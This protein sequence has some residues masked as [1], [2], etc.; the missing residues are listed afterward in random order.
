[1]SEIIY[2]PETGLF[3]KNGKPFGT[4]HKSGYIHFWFEGKIKLAH[5][6]AWKMY[7]GDWPNGQ[8]DHIN[9][10]KKDNRISN[11][12]LATPSQNRMN[13]KG[14][15]EGK[16]KGV[17]KHRSKFRSFVVVDGVRV[18]SKSFDTELEAAN[19]YQEQASLHYKEFARFEQ[20]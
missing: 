20:T 13:S 14:L 12:R 18:W 2:C 11:L 6:V 10:N 8:I 5:R 1:L 19:W 17:Y 15:R 3:Y 7:Y 9:G 16:T 4:N